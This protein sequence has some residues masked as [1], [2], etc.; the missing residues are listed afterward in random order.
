MDVGCGL[1]SSLARPVFGC[2]G[3][4]CDLRLSLSFLA[5]VVQNS[6]V[7]LSCF[8][9]AALLLVMHKENGERDL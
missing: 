1:I 3:L 4:F 9:L 5:D 2:N 8:K 6:N 7:V